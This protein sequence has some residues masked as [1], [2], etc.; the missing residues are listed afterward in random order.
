M[1]THSAGNPRELAVYDQII[2]DFNAS[3][4]EYEV[5]Y[6][7]FPQLDYNTSVVSAAQGGLPCLLDVD[8]PVTPAWAWSGMETTIVAALW[9]GAVLTHLREIQK[10]SPPVLSALLCVAAGLTRPDGILI[11]AVIGSSLG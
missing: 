7:A 6:V 1:W 8:G 5:Q 9:I 11:A 4:D 3:Q 10:N 2:A